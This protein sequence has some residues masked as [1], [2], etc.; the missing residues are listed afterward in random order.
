MFKSAY[1]SSDFLVRNLRRQVKQGDLS[2]LEPLIQALNVVGH[3]VSVARNDPE[4][5]FQHYKRM[6][7]YVLRLPEN[8][9]R[10]QSLLSHA[11]TYQGEMRRRRGDL[12]GAME[13]FRSAPQGP[14]V[15][16]L[17]RGNRAQLLARV[18]TDLS[19]AESMKDALRQ[20]G[21]SYDLLSEAEVGECGIY[22]CYTEC[23]TYIEYARFYEN[24]NI[25]KSLEYIERAEGLA[26]AG[27]RWQIP[28]KINKGKLLLYRAPSSSSWTGFVESDEFQGGMKV[29]EEAI[30]LVY[31]AG[32][33]RQ[34][35]Q[36]AEIK[37][38]LFLRGKGY[39]DA[40]YQLNQKLESRDKLSRNIVD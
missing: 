21:R 23:G 25:K 13:A 30:D 9:P 12:E 16:P 7:H 19:D 3:A 5:A 24:S 2:L 34:I 29:L 40:G 8:D 35:V 26:P 22:V 11:R 17:V 10:L 6:E 20:L 31:N 15:E 33:Q 4:Q 37:N 18:Y 32:H 39:F 36:I 14:E 1:A 27:S 28:V 38:N